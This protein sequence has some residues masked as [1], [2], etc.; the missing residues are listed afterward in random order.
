[1]LLMVL[2]VPPN[3]KYSADGSMPET[4]QPQRHTFDPA[5]HNVVRTIGLAPTP[6]AP[7]G[8]QLLL[9]GDRRGKYDRSDGKGGA[10][11]AAE[12]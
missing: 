8:S 4:R 9:G 12:A 1:M 5:L 6:P 10:F 2:A 11:T 3:A 7:A